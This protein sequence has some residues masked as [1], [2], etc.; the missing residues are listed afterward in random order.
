[1]T[2]YDAEAMFGK[3]TFHSTMHGWILAMECF[4]RAKKDA[5]CWFHAEHY[6]LHSPCTVEGIDP[7]GVD[8]RLLNELG[9][10]VD[11]ETWSRFT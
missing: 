6:I 5:K 1:M 9:W 11:E 2:H 3:H 7:D 10:H 8:G 4:Q